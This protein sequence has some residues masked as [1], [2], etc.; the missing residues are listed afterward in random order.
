MMPEDLTD[1]RPADLLD[2]LLCGSPWQACVCPPE[3]RTP[4]E[5][6]AARLL[7]DGGLTAD[8]LAEIERVILTPETRA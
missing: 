4:A 5:R 3:P 1:E 8:D 6:A 7:R 2:C